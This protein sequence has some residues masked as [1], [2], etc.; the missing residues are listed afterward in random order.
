MKLSISKTR[1]AK[2]PARTRKR[3]GRKDASADDANAS[4][5]AKQSK[6]V[7]EN[8]PMAPEPNGD[9]EAEGERSASAEPKLPSEVLSKYSARE[10][11]LF[12]EATDLPEMCSHFNAAVQSVGLEHARDDPD[13]YDKLRSGLLPKLNYK[14]KAI[15]KVR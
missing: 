14:Q 12:L 7:E 2:A 10:F 13:F 9:T 8:T 6:I 3:D 15:F 11:S 4:P 5:P 1:Q